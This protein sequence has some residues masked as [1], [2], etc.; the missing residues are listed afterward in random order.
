MTVWERFL[1]YAVMDTQSDENASA[2]PSTPKQLELAKV[3]VEDLKEIG[4]ENAYV[5]EYGYVY[6]SLDAT[7]GLEDYYAIGLIAHMDTAPAFSGKN[8]KPR[9][10]NN[11]DGSDICLNAEKNI[12][13]DTKTFPN[14]LNYIGEDMIVT[15]GT[16][17]LGADDKAGIAEIITA[18][19]EIIRD[20]KAHGRI[21]VAFTPDEE[22]GS[23]A[24]YF[25]IKEFGVDFAYTVDGGAVGEIEYENFNAASLKVIV[26][27]ANIHPGE[28]KN[29]MKN[30]ALIAMEYNNMLP[31]AE[32]PAHT[33]G[34]EGFYHLCNMTGNEEYAQ[35]DYIVRDHDKKQFSRRK[36]LA[37]KAAEYLNEKYGEGTCE[38]VLKDSYYNMKEKIEPHMYIVEKAVKAMEENNVVPRIVP[39]RGGT[40]GARLSFEG[41]LC[42]NISTGGNNFH[43]K[44][45][46]IT[47][48]S[49]EKMTEVIKSIL[50]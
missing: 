40:D 5:D 8:V 19:E 38:T 15:D 36:E 32:T 42:P 50:K 41:L 44:Y 17:L 14:L 10:I 24:R 48:Q 6:G 20:K 27:G 29:K 43:G 28:A 47:I 1:K 16:T 34:Y 49:L 18:L 31:P 33:E 3:L 35:L 39:I 26:K 4:V 7:E 13:M 2:S 37:Q 12:V 25:K 9:V 23:G 11:Y 30:A 22:I 46:F 45:E 21:A